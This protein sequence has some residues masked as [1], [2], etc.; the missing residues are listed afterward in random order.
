M[1]IEQ[2]DGFTCG[3]SS[4]YQLLEDAVTCRGNT[5]VYHRKIS[6]MCMHSFQFIADID[7][8]LQGTARCNQGCTNTEGSYICT[9]NSGYQLHHNDLSLCVGTLYSLLT[10]YAAIKYCTVQILMN[11]WIPM[12]DVIITVTT[13]LAVICALVIMDIHSDQISITA[14]V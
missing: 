4:G 9:C 14:K 6:V 7:E 12:E 10:L 3:C 1:C 11:V 13:L 8:C 5:S 2:I